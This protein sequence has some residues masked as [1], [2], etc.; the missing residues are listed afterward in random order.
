MFKFDLGDGLDLRILERRHAA[1]FL[2]FVDANRAHLSVWLNWGTSIVTLADAEKF[3]ERGLNRF[4][5]DGLPCTGIW[6]DNV[7]VGGILFFP[8]DALP[9]STE[10]GYWLGESA[11]GRGIM[12]RAVRA[13]LSFVFDD[14]KL[15]RVALQ[16]DVRNTRSRAVA[17]RVG[18]TFEGIRRQ[19][20]VMH[21]EL[22][23]FAAYA[24]L[25]SDWRALQAA[26]RSE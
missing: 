1:E 15:N 6:L 7:M 16:T 3:I 5:A 11:S 17:E 2:A 18:F 26:S 4:A 21:E 23:D 22:I 19:A 24:M 10:I 25:A 20:W 14:L 8:V 13:M 9:R 12:T